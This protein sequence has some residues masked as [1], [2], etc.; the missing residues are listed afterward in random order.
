MYVCMYVCLCVCMY[1]C[2]YVSIY[3][4]MYVNYVCMYVSMYAVPMLSLP[5]VNMLSFLCLG[6]YS[7]VEREVPLQR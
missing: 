3:V 4:C 2:M 6:S 5:L 7:F 1:V